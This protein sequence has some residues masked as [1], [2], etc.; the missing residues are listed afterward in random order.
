MKFTNTVKNTN[1]RREN[2][3]NLCLTAHSLKA[4]NF[5]SRTGQ[6]EIYTLYRKPLLMRKPLQKLTFGNFVNDGQKQTIALN[7]I[8]M[9]LPQIIL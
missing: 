6:L 4:R 3:N 8:R 7:L 5:Q 9:D 2:I 1:R